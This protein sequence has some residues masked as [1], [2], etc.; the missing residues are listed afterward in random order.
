MGV[1]GASKARAANCLL[2]SPAQL[3]PSA[4]FRSW[5]TPTSF[6]QNEFETYANT[7]NSEAVFPEL[8]Y[9]LM[10]QSVP[11]ANARTI[12][13]KAAL[14]RSLPFGE[15]TWRRVTRFLRAAGEA[16]YWRLQQGQGRAGTVGV[17]TVI[18]LAA[19]DAAAD[20]AGSYLR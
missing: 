8:L 18:A 10:R 14:L 15:E 2:D 19:D 17:G 9:L 1:G 7:H 13:Q 11:E 20:R 6:P 4:D 16:E 12:A 5:T 3:G